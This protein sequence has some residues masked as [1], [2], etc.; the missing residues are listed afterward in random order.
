MNKEIKRTINKRYYQKHKEE[1][2]L[3]RQNHKQEIKLGNKRCNENRKRRIF[4]HYG[5]I[6]ICCGETEPTFLTIDHING[7]GSKHLK[8]LGG[9][10]KLY[11]WLIKNNFPEGFQTLC[12][13]CNCSKG[14]YGQCVHEKFKL[15]DLTKT[16]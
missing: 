8:E 6:C 4:D 9:G 5:W 2:L 10:G 7:G 13:N 12:Y 15:I 1:L 16:P 14:H 3:R 11:G